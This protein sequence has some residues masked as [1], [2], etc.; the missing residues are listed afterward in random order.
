[1]PAIALMQQ[2]LA[3]CS[4]VRLLQICLATL[5]QQA[6]SVP[7]LACR[8]NK[9]KNGAR[10]KSRQLTSSPICIQQSLPCRF[11]C[12][13]Q[14]Y[15]DTFYNADHHAADKQGC[16]ARSGTRWQD[17]CARYC[18]AHYAQAPTGGACAR[19][20]GVAAVHYLNS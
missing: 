1:M 3:R 5:L 11:S 8:T 18:K 14:N 12:P 20:A 9:R 4:S 15:I 7:Y 6:T 16:R 10:P 17:A 19:R 2:K 13:I